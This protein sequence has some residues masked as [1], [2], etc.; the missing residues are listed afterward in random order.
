MIATIVSEPEVLDWRME[1]L[2]KLGFNWTQARQLSI[3]ADVD[4][5]QARKMIY[6]GCST[7]LAF[8]ILI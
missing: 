7:D 6:A 4:L 5:N 1:Q 3:L 8:Q 2:R